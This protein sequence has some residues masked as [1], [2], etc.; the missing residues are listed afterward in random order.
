MVDNEIR[1]GNVFRRMHR[2]R[3]DQ[4]RDKIDS[5]QVSDSLKTC[6]ARFTAERKPPMRSKSSW[7]T[8]ALLYGRLFILSASLTRKDAENMDP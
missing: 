7:S 2:C 4:K 3:K 8:C 6:E 5:I 1:K